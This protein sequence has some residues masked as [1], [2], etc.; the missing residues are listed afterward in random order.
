MVAVGS[1]KPEN[2]SFL[3][4][5]TGNPSKTI[6]FVNNENKLELKGALTI[7]GIEF[8]LGSVK[9]CGIAEGKKFVLKDP[10]KAY[11]R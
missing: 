7:R 11:F 6:G 1:I 5:H 8:T 3:M 10:V 2:A 9:N 4:K